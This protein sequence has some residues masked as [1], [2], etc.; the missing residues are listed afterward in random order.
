MLV[1]KLLPDTIDSKIKNAIPLVVGLFLPKYIKGAAGMALG[2]G[3]IATGGL[4]LIQDFGILN[5]IGETP[6]IAAFRN[7]RQLNGI[8]GSNDNIPQ[9]AGISDDLSPMN[10]ALYA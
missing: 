2:A 5:G 3:M 10:V 7:M 4:K 9:V 8:D 1:G 6:M